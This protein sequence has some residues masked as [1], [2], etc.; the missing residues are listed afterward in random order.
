[1]CLSITQ[2][3]ILD[4]AIDTS[5]HLSLWSWRE[6]KGQSFQGHKKLVKNNVI[7]GRRTAVYHKS[8]LASRHLEMETN[9]EWNYKERVCVFLK[10]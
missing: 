9:G 3:S 4:L 2:R 8:N 10:T 5:C 1:M 6:E 7:T